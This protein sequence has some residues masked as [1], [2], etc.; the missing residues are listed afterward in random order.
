MPRQM[1]RPTMGKLDRRFEVQARTDTNDDAGQPVVTWST[2]ATVWGSLSPLD[3]DEYP[4]IGSADVSYWVW[5]R[6]LEGVTPRHRLRWVP[7][8][9]RDIPPAQT[10]QTARYFNIVAAMIQGRYRWLQL[11][12]KEKL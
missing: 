9:M 7:W 8:Q 6:Y 3:G 1:A 11:L 2:I 4:D 10:D 5:M 12:V